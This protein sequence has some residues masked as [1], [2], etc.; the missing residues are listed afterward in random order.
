MEGPDKLADDDWDEIDFE[1]SSVSG[2]QTED[3]EKE[4]LVEVDE[5]EFVGRLADG[6]QWAADVGGHRW[7]AVE[8][9]DEGAVLVTLF[10][11]HKVGAFQ[12]YTLEQLRDTNT[13]TKLAPQS[14]FFAKSMISPS[15]HLR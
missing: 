7:H 14:S 15:Q 3:L 1:P 10:G 9:D 11:R 5:N 13:I 6:Q 4:R 12:T 2:E 8:H